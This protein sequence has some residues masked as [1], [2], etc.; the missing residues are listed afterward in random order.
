MYE[1]PRN[2]RTKS[3][4]WAKAE[5]AASYA[6]MNRTTAIPATY[7]PPE[8]ASDP[9]IAEKWAK[10]LETPGGM[11]EVSRDITSV[12]L[13]YKSDRTETQREMRKHRVSPRPR[14][15]WRSARPRRCP[16]SPER[17]PRGSTACC[18]SASGPP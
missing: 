4:E 5:L 9:A 11:A 13:A 3:D 14:P 12:E 18:C 6:T 15:S 7:V 8:S 1:A 10:Q 16:R 17:R 2:T